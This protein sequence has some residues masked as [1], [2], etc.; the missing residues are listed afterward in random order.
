MPN[1]NSIPE[2]LYQPNQPY[3]YYY[4]NLP[5]KNILTRV[6]LINIQVDYNT[7]L[8]RGCSGTAGS[9]SNRLDHSLNQDGSLKT[10]SV[11]EVGHNIAN[12][13]DGIDENGE[14]YVRMKES[15]R[16][17]LNEISSSANNFSIQIED[18]EGNYKLPTESNDVLRIVNSSTIQFDFQAPNV[19]TAHS[20]YPPE[21]AHKHNYDLSPA[22]DNPSAPSYQSFKTT[23]LETPFVE[24]S[25]KVYVN[26]I[27]ITNSA[28]AV[29]NSDATTWT[30]TFVETQDHQAG[31]FQLNRALSNTDVVRIDFD[32]SY[33]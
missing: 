6:D 33:V 28:V 20:V 25:L 21:F 8:I 11:D 5:L 1:I 9:L 10:T 23:A 12:H 3:H 4:D 15:E 18:L 27:R 14:S 22:Y 29:P 24:G 13:T 7:D 2:V 16:A 32:E 17:K 30:S 31:T 19:L 26:G